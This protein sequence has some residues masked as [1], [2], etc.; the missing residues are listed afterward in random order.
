[1]STKSGYTEETSFQENEDKTIEKGDTKFKQTRI[2][3]DRTIN[4]S[5]KFMQQ[6]DKKNRM[7]Q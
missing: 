1:M 3:D 5:W 6:E 2:H 7:T 4:I